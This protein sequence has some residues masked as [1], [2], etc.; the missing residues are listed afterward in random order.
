MEIGITAL[1]TFIVA[2]ELGPGEMGK[3]IP[4]FLFL[5]YSAYLTLGINQVMIKNY[6]K[7][8]SNKEE[9]D[10]LIINLQYHLLAG[11]I[12]ITLSY[13][14]LSNEYWLFVGFL[15]AFTILRSYFMT[16]FRVID[17]IHVLNKNNI[18]FSLLFLIG[19]LVFVENLY[20]YVLIWAISMA[21]GIICYFIDAYKML[22]TIRKRFLTL[23]F[24]LLKKLIVEGVKLIGIGIITTI[25]LT[26]DRLI[27]NELDLQKDILGNYQVADFFGKAFYMI[28]TTV[29][30]YYYPKMIYRLQNEHAYR[31]IFFKKVIL[32]NIILVV[33]PV[34]S[35][36]FIELIQLHFFT[37]YDL[38]SH[39]T[40]FNVLIKSLVFS[41]SL[42]SL[43]FISVNKEVSYLRNYVPLLAIVA[44]AYFYVKFYDID[45]RLIGF[46]LLSVLMLTIFTQ[47][48]ACAKIIFKTNE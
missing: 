42:F 34:C 10:F 7:L 33:F 13:I 16:Y 17:R 43:I 29:L 3:S 6:K 11:A 39:F 48:R 25:L 19:V 4:I 18:I 32:V 14:L 40:L 20:Q 12:A 24:D 23:N 31:V 41:S 27:L 44:G 46:V 9:Q 37:N 1:T 21:I 2:E 38:L 5:T 47:Y 28:A 15:S 36:F 45:Y 35:F 22:N 30:F 26:F 8:Q